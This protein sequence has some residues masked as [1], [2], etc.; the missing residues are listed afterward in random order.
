MALMLG[1][2]A[3]YDFNKTY[4]GPSLFFLGG[5]SLSY[6]E[7]V[8]DPLFSAHRI[9]DNQ[10]TNSTFYISDNLIPQWTNINFPTT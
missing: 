2:G 6:Y 8:D 10:A 5:N 1:T 7:P 9:F 4:G 3:R